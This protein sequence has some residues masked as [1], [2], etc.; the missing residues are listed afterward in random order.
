MCVVDAIEEFTKTISRRVEVK[1]RTDYFYRTKAICEALKVIGIADKP[2]YDFSESDV[3]DLFYY[4]E[5]NPQRAH[6]N[7]TTVLKFE[8]H[9]IRFLK[10]AKDRNAIQDAN[11]FLVKPIKAKSKPIDAFKKEEREDYWP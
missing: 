9:F 1:T 10:F 4:F 2:I 11:C 8:K 7:R 3:T 5:R 6:L